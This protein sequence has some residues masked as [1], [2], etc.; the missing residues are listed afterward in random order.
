MSALESVDKNAVSLERLIYSQK[1]FASLNEE[2]M[3]IL[4]SISTLKK[5][6]KNYIL[7]YE[8]KKSAEL[9][10]LVRGLAR[11]YKMDKH[12]NETFLY[13][14]YANSLISEITDLESDYIDSYSNIE[15][16]EDAYILHINYQKFKQHFL[17]NNKLWGAL[18]KEILKRSEQLQGL[19]NREFLFDA[20]SKVSMML[21]G[22]LEMFNKL[23]RHDIALMLHIQPSTLSR[24]L[25]KLKRNGVIDIIQGKVAVKNHKA[26]E[27]IYKDRVDE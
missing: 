21:G 8:K 15:L 26:L 5:Y 9:L 18:T 24:V 1:F 6:K 10:F 16:I 25:N 4:L 14:I 22:D 7:H 2:E 23:K 27:D 11:A 19:I 20:V 3:D 13:Y 17:Q 12:D